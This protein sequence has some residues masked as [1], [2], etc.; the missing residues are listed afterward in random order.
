MTSILLAE[1]DPAIRRL[2]RVQLAR[3][4]VTVL[5][6]TDGRAALALARAALPSVAVLDL[7]LPSLNGFEI[8]TQLKAE[9]A[10][11]DIHVFLLTA[12]AMNDVQG[13]TTAAGADAVFTKPWGTRAMCDAIAD[14]IDGPEAA[15]ARASDRRP[16]ELAEVEAEPPGACASADVEGLPPP[17]PGLERCS[18]CTI[19]IGPGHVENQ[20]Y[21]HEARP[22][23]VCWSCFES[24]Q[25][26]AERRAEAE[27]QPSA[28]PTD[29]P[30]RR[31]P[32][33]DPRPD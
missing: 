16:A 23:V 28:L 20:S 25:R 1:T 15:L 21:V 19:L 3:M 30:R 10:T 18:E 24:L 4:G 8:C 12:T 29:L 32:Q 13:Y 9:D 31:S 17:P 33:D 5:E 14:L 6:A 2:L 27:R 7:D 22:G 26:Q 11:Q